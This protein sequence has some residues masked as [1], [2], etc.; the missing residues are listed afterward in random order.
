MSLRRDTMFNLAGAGLPLAAAAVLI[1]FTL[2]R[3]G[4]EAFG[5]LALVWGLI[6]YFSLFDM[7]VGRAL[8]F[9]LSRLRGTRAASQV[10]PTLRAGLAI[11]GG[12]GL[13][14]ALLMLLLAGPLV[15]AW[16]KIGPSLQP[17]ALLAFRIAAIGVVPTTVASGMRGAL[18]GMGRFGASNLN[19]ILLGLLTAAVPALSILAHGNSLGLIALYLVLARLVVLLGT[20]FQLRA[21]LT[22]AGEPLRRTHL[23]RLFGYGFWLTVS[24]IVGPL[25]TYGDR[26]FVGTAV[27][28]GELPFYVIPQEGL[29]RLLIIPTALSGALLPRLTSLRPEEAASAYRKNFRRVALAMLGVC[30]LTVLVAYPALAW[31][32][33]EEFARRAFPV[34]VVLILGVWINSLATVPFTLLHALGNPRVTALFHVVELVLYVGTLWLLTRWFGLVGAALAW[35]LR[36]TLDLVLLRVAARKALPAVGAHPRPAG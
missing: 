9:E 25:M 13:V 29:Q 33:S 6:G 3:L 23:R 7:G 36:T 22:G 24:G 14:G 18:D 11:T 20:S 10:P 32:L 16:L 19:R 15:H 8:T 21:E 5:V 30:A 28:V 31:W 1:P 27:G 2:G 4:D 17:D 12:A 35:S 34:V 26:F